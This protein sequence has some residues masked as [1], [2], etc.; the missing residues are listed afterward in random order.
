M[1]RSETAGWP[2]AAHDYD[3]LVDVQG[4]AKMSPVAAGG[5]HLTGKRPVDLCITQGGVNTIAD[6]QEQNR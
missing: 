2:V 3:G 6:Q 4:Q 5:E 1:R